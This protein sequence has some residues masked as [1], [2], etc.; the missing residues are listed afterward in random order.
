MVMK[1]IFFLLILFVTCF[2]YAD[3]T[4]YLKKVSE[5]KTEKS[6]IKG[7]DFIYLIN[8]DQRPENY[9]ELSPSS[10]PITSILTDFQLFMAQDFQ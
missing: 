3:L 7:I 10:I 1:I 6:T 5:K 2:G 8:L 9:K 4:P